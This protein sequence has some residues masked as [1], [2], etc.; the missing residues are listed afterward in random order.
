MR[1]VVIISA[2]PPPM[3]GAAKNSKILYDDLVARGVD[4]VK[5]DTSV[6]KLSHN[7]GFGYHRAR[8][9]KF[10]YNAIR[11]FWVLRRGDVC[12][13][14]PDGGMGL[15]YSLGYCLIGFIRRAE[16]VLHYRNYSYI[17][18]PSKLLRGILSLT[19]G[20]VLHVF[21]DENMRSEFSSR[22]TIDGGDIVYNSAFLP[23]SSVD[24]SWRN[25]VGFI[26]VGYLSNLCREK[27]LYRVIE[28]ID[29]A[30][31]LP[32]EFL[33]GGEAVSPEDRKSLEDCVRRSN[34]RVTLFGHLS[35]V[36]KENFYKK[37]DIFLFPTIF[38]QEAQ[39][40]VIWEA[41][42]AGLFVLSHDRGSVRWM[43]RDGLGSILSEGNYAADFMLI[44]KSILS[45]R[46]NLH[47][48][49]ID[50]INEVEEKRVEG[51]QQYK[52]LLSRLVGGK[53]KAA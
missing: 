28:I 53:I 24:V 18:R 15:V 21:L 23:K 44:V 7:R 47:K 3:G 19:R 30:K 25:G 9:S 48:V 43:L 1:K 5:V 22:Y 45:G 17:D 4:C 34:G 20:R 2:F 8:L 27:G 52:K 16:F 33:I 51:L 40:N 14:V 50:L 42:S 41:Q 10:Y 36:E 6:G 32:V 31:D 13:M 29:A 11:L 39:P 35:G 37:C 26:K 12:Y 46:L 38:A 49:G